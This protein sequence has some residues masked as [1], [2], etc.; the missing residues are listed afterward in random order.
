MRKLERLGPL[1]DGE[2]Q[3]LLDLSL[4]VQQ[5]CAHQDLVRSGDPALCCLLLLDGI[6]CRHKLLRGGRRQI[7]A[8]HVAGDLTDLTALLLEQVDCNIGTLTPAKVAF[9]PHATVLG[10]AEPYPN[11]MRLLW[12]DTLITAAVLQEWVVNVGQ[13]P[14]YERVAH[15]LCEQVS[16]MR[17]VGLAA[18]HL[19]ELPLTPDVLADATAL[20]I[21][22][23]DRALRELQYEGL[24]APLDRSLRV[25]DW[26][27][28]KRAGGFDPSY[29][30][31]LGMAA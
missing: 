29:L 26:D 14:E 22:H 20:P 4:D 30:H 19:C 27:G 6:A 28:L 3:M 9:I 21:A 31:Q 23:V 15:L 1:L 8:F 18:G 5:V 13:R 25:L 11:L 24:I 2:R 7:M 12:L 17:A 16:R 10:W